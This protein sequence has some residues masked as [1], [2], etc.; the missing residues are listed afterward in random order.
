MRKTLEDLYYGNISPW[1]QQYRRN[2]DYDKAIRTVS[3][4]EE[5]LK[6]LLGEKEQALLK[7]MV[8]AQSTINGITAMENFIIGFRLGL[9]LGVEV[10]DD[11]DGCVE[12]I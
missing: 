8:T 12:K 3:E 1:E 5:Q 7:E 11:G 9:R 10:M 2:T 4:K 6:L